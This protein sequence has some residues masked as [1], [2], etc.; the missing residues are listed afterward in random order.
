MRIVDYALVNRN[1]EIPLV[2]VDNPPD[3]RAPEPFLQT[4]GQSRAREAAYATAA[5][6]KQSDDAAIASTV[7]VV[8]ELRGGRSLSK[9]VDKLSEI[10]GVSAVN[11]GEEGLISD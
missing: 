7:V 10:E 11:V 4:P 3:F 8:L 6:L 5:V 9:L 2:K 1:G